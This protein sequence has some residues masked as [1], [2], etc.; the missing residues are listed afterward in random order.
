MSI[1]KH[2][3]LKQMKKDEPNVGS[4][5][6]RRGEGRTYNCGTMTAVFKADE[7]ETTAKYSVSEW[8]LE[9]NSAGPGA[10]L[11]EENDEVFYVIGGKPFWLAING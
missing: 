9:P 1:V 3:N 4:I 7:E 10:H 5:I 2:V 8:W 6:L 11:H